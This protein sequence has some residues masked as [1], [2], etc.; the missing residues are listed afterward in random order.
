MPS[1]PELVQTV[2]IWALPVLFAITLHEVAHGW[3]ARALGDNTAAMM[4]RL[5]LNPLKHIDPVGTIIVPLVFVLMQTSFLFG[6]ARPVPVS[7]NNLRQPRRDIAL[8]AVAG[9]LAN[10][11]MALAWGLLLKLALTQDVDQGMWLGIGL[12]AKVGVGFNLM[13]VA[14][15]LLPIPPLDG[16][17]VLSSLLPPKL[18]WQF[19]RIEP[20]GMFILVGLMFAGL[21]WP[22]MRPL[23]VAGHSLVA[24]L[25]GLA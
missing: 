13:L 15:N 9:P 10:L 8:V 11:A 14:L 6:W 5:S 21:L 22:L 12:M 23:L 25:L 7:T 18:S 20:Y 1:M 24:T 4:G 16:S 17:K 3:A 2:A 19:G